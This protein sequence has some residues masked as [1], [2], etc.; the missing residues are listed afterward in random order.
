MYPSWQLSM[1]TSRFYVVF[2]N[3]VIYLKKKKNNHENGHHYNPCVTLYNN[4]N[5]HSKFYLGCGT[6]RKALSSCKVSCVR[7]KFVSVLFF[8]KLG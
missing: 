7:H 6:A 3:F 4:A 5:L 1:N 8:F 2:V